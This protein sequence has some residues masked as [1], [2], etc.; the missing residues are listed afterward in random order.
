MFV[1]SCPSKRHLLLVLAALSNGMQSQWVR[2]R[3]SE[4]GLI[5]IKAAVGRRKNR[6]S[7]N[8][9]ATIY[10]PAG[11]IYRAINRAKQNESIGPAVAI[12][13][14]PIHIYAF[15]PQ[16]PTILFDHPPSHIHTQSTTKLAMHL[17]THYRI[18][19]LLLTLIFTP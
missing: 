18:I 15:A 12:G 6:R 17:I 5:I 7:S 2:F 9:A 4:N 8:C 10:C 16:L 1:F 19:H 13:A 11:T 3:L 14:P